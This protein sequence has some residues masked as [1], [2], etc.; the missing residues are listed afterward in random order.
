MLNLLWVTSTVPDS[1]STLKTLG[2]MQMFRRLGLKMV[3]Q[4]CIFTGEKN[5]WFSG[6]ILSQFMMVSEPVLSSQVE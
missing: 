3:A 6:I 2:Y 1:Q 5:C 4:R